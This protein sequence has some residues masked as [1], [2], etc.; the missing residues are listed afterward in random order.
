MNEKIAW[1]IP[2]PRPLALKLMQTIGVPAM[3]GLRRPSIALDDTAISEDLDS[4]RLLL[5]GGEPVLLLA[6]LDEP[7]GWAGWEA[8]S[9]AR[10]EG[11]ILPVMVLSGDASVMKG[12]RLSP[13][14]MPEA[15][16]IWRSLYIPVSSK[17]RILNLLKLTG[18]RRDTASLL[19]VDGLLLDPGRRQ[20]SRME[21]SWKMPPRNSICCIIWQ[22][23]WVKSVPVLRYYSRCA[24]VPFS[25]GHQ[26]GG[27]VPA[28]AAEGG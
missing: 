26:C 5:S 7:G 23:T 9:E 24:G 17:R 20:V 18:R 25:C 21:R 11:M 1:Y 10:K 6:E 2:G 19:K 15:T 27:C 12:K 28:S 8:V 4:L 14:S 3:P 22:R 13:S 16:N